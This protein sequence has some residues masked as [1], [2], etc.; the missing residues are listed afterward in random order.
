MENLYHFSLFIYLK[1]E[2][3]CVITLFRLRLIKSCP[4]GKYVIIM[5]SMYIITVY[6]TLLFSV[7]YI[8]VVL[9][10]QLSYSPS[11]T[12][13]TSE[14]FVEQ[15]VVSQV[16]T[17]IYNVWNKRYN[18]LTIVLIQGSTLLQGTVIREARG[19]TPIACCS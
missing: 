1:I 11:N 18:S 4:E 5:I 13:N 2:H 10:L 3:I 6:F 15:T 12:A 7:I 14:L 17:S 16:L 19:N 8:P 9:V